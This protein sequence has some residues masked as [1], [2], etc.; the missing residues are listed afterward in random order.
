M[1]AQVLLDLIRERKS[2]RGLFD[3]DRPIEPAVLQNILDAATW[4]PT[5]HNMQ[6]FEIIVV[7][8]KLLLTQISELESPVSPVFLKENY[9]QLSFSEEELRCRKTGILAGQFPPAWLSEEAQ[10]G[11]LTPV[12]GKLG[13]MIRRGP[14]LLLVLYDPSRRAPAS[15]GDFLGVIS[16]GTM[17]E[18]MW[19]MAEAQG[20]ALHVVCAFGKEPLSSEVKRLLGVPSTLDITLGIRLGY[21]VVEDNGLRVRRDRSDFVSY[22]RYGK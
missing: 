13:E 12:A 20:V 2:S 15:E 8:D 9:A 4:A 14:V 22:N 6:N 19:L 16:L 7:D 3:Q 17:L 11:K 21:P 1:E 5:A 10:Q 18:N